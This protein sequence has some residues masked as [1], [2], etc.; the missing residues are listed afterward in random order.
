MT[1]NIRLA[2]VRDAA[3]ILAIY[4][5]YC[6]STTVTFEV[7]PPSLATMEE[8]IERITTEYP[9]LI[10]EIDGRVAGYVY[11]SRF[12]ER[13]AYR[14]TAEAAVYVALDSQRRGLGRAMYTALFSILQTQGLFRAVAGITVPNPASVG[15]HESLGFKQVGLFPAVGHKDGTWLNVGWWQ[16]A[17]QPETLHPPDPRPFPTL[18]DDPLV[19]AALKS[20]ADT[21][22]S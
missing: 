12:R 17:L 13:A 15:L 4:A 6:E 20:A 11:A 10:G 19:A 21:V 2:Q 5:P 16:L 14:W 18:S 22:N 8:R 3:D 9:W 1:I 7:V